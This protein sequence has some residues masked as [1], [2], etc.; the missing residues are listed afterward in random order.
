M[1]ADYLLDESGD[2][3]NVEIDEAV[4]EQ[5]EISEEDYREAQADVGERRE[6]LEEWARG[7]FTD[8]DQRQISEELFEY[9]SLVGEGNS[10][11]DTTTL[12]SL[13]ESAGQ[14]ADLDRA[15][16]DDLLGTR[17]THRFSEIRL[18]ADFPI[19]TVVYGYSRTE[20][21]L[22]SSVSR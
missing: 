5:L 3:G 14:R 8:D 10:D 15:L 20:A 1:I 13:Q 6:Q 7:A 16:V 18:I 19:T 22:T 4:L 9:Q 12:E 2:S 21:E 11:I 17:D